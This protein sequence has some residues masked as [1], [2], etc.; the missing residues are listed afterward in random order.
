[1]SKPK[2]EKCTKCQESYPDYCLENGFCRD[3]K[4]CECGNEFG[5]ILYYAFDYDLQ[6][7]ELVE[8]CSPSCFMINKGQHVYVVHS[9]KK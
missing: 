6:D 7:V 8:R 2:S 1:M 9:V 3:C 4:P 5:K